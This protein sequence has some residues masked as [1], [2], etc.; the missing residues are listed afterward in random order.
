MGAG[1]V[2]GTSAPCSWSS[3]S[4]RCKLA[5]I[6]I[7]ALTRADLAAAARPARLGVMAA[8]FS[9]MLFTPLVNGP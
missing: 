6:G 1:R 5:A 7:V 4:S 2:V 9:A 8:L 3:A